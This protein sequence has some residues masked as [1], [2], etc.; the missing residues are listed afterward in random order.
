MNIRNLALL[1]I[2]IEVA[3]ILHNWLHKER[4]FIDEKWY[5]ED[6][7]ADVCDIPAGELLNLFLD[8]TETQL[9][10]RGKSKRSELVTI[11]SRLNTD[12]QINI[13]PQS[14]LI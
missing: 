4:D 8:L 3:C 5:E 11:L 13:P 9:K 12:A 7:G 10:N 2:L 14:N 1:S 6:N